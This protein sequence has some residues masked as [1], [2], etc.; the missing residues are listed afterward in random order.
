M[1]G[2]IF[3]ILRYFSKALFEG[4][5]FGGAYI[6]REICVSKPIGLAL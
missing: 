1:E 5:F 6:R 3:G 4:L 2:L